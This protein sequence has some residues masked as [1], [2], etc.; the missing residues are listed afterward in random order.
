MT[1]RSSTAR[2]EILQLV[3]LLVVDAV[4]YFVLIPQGVTDPESF[5]IDQGLP[6]SFAPRL[7]AVLAALL[8]LTRLVR[9]LRNNDLALASSV[10]DEDDDL[11]SGIPYRGIGGMIVALFFSIIL[12]PIVG[13]H[14][15]G[16]L[17]LCAMLLIMGERRWTHLI[18][19]PLVVSTA[20]WLLF[21]QLLSIRLPT[22]WLF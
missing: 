14:I 1:A 17:L 12:V 19:F 10:T 15:G 9:V 6:P 5:G 21:G 20:V 16:A 11:S 13:F 2:N 22:G 3:I 18:L 7:V 4:F 8:M